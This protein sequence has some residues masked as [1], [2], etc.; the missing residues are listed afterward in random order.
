[1]EY[2]ILGGAS[3]QE[4]YRVVQHTSNGLGILWGDVTNN[5]NKNHYICNNEIGAT[6]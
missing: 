1:M 4:I 2:N 3:R 5:T 6:D